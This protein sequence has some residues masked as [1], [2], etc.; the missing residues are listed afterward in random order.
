MLAFERGL[1]PAPRLEADTVE[2]SCRGVAGAF[3]YEAA[4]GET[5]MATG[6]PHFPPAA[7]TADPNGFV[8]AC[9]RHP[10]GIP[11]RALP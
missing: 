2:S 6:G 4:N 5:T 11:G 3:R 9:G 7:R 8:V 1:R 10:A